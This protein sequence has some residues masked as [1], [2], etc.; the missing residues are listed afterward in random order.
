[1]LD[2]NGWLHTGDIGTMD[3]DG[4]VEI[5]DRK[6]ELIITAGGENIAPSLIEAHLKSVHG[7]QQA[8]VVGDKRRFLAALIVLDPAKLPTLAAAAGVAVTTLAEAASSSALV[9]YVQRQIDVANRS[10]AR[11]Q[12]VKRIALLTEEFSI[13]GGELTP[14]LKL[15]RRVVNEKYATIIERLYA[16]EAS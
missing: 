7:V 15:K 4:F 14:S 1:V 8:V 2:A 11:V 3:A 10:L 5:T 6:K 16:T 13:E 9:E 12:T